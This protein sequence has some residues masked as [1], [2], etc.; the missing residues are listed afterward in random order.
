MKLKLYIREAFGIQWS[1]DRIYYFMIAKEKSG[2]VE[3]PIFHKVMGPY[4]VYYL[5]VP[6]IS[7]SDNFVSLKAYID[8]GIARIHAQCER[9][10]TIL[11][12]DG[13]AENTYAVW[14]REFESWLRT[15]GREIQWQKI[16]DLPMYQE[17]K[18]VHN[19]IFLLQ[20]IPTGRLPAQLIILGGAPGL[21]DIL[22]G[23]ARHMKQITIYAWDPPREFEYIR[24]TLLEEYGLC[25]EWKKGL[26]PASAEPALVLDYSGKEKIYV[27]DIVPESIW[28]DMTSMESRRHALED[29][30]TGIHYL[31]L[32]SIWR[33]E[34]QQTLDTMRKI[35]YNVGVKLSG[36]V[37]L[38]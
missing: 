3:L 35:Q 13:A 14:D 19:I 25:T 36:K 30:E 1:M 24:H 31:S 22:E 32:K 21:T 8:K 7:E 26:Q 4:E 27:W 33:T 10:G 37:D 11:V 34:I 12:A 28:I 6:K 38:L 20:Q 5:Q 16:W 29:R 17:Y 15:D 2:K 9:G 18:E 23:L